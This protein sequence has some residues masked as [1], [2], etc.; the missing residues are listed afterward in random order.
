MKKTLIILIFTCIPYLLYSQVTIKVDTSI[1]YQTFS[2]WETATFITSDC[3]SNQYV[4]RD[5]ILPVL[6]DSVGISRIRLEVRS[7]VENNIDNFKKFYENDCPSGTDTNYL[8]WRESRYATVNDNSDT[9]INFNGFFF[10]DL[11]FRIEKV[12]LPLKKLLEERGQSLYINLC[13]VAFTGQ[14]KN[15]IYIHNN[16]DEYAEFV[17]VTYL[18]IYNKYG[19]V[20]DAW[21]LVLEPDNVSQ[22]NGNLLGQAIVKTAERLKKYNFLPRFI[23]PSNTNMTTAIKYFDDMVK[24]PGAIDYLEEICYH[25]YSGVSQQS[26][27]EL[28][29]RGKQYSKKTSMLEWWFDNAKYNILHEDITIGNAS[30]FQQATISGFFDIDKTDLK[31]PKIKLKDI[32]QYNR[33]YYTLIMPNAQ[34][35]EAITSNLIASGLAFVNS[36]NTFGLIVKADNDTVINIEGLPDGKYNVITT[37]SNEKYKF[38]NQIEV[39]NNLINNIKVKKGLFALNQ[40]VD[41]N[42]VSDLSKS[43]SIS[44]NPASDYIEINVGAGSKPALMVEFEI[45]NI[46]GE[47]TTLSDLSPALSEGEGERKI[48]ISNLPAGVYFIKIGDKLAK[49]VKMYNK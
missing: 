49:F 30:S 22:W 33:I 31:N 41:I 38:H 42:S 48:D 8:K 9:S 34:R 35:K 25:R 17:L 10:T 28:A 36:N 44:P 16:P 12:V 24:V 26:L 2:G 21:E 32:T 27:I 45:F 5:A 39:K 1:S 20:P 14:I 7:G 47:K 37:N 13:Y 18:H 40:I 29:K 23:G 4:L 6:I 3:D 43:I 46:F 15:G 11:D 19:F